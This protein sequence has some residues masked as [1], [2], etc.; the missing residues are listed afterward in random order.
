[1]TIVT[2]HLFCSGLY[3]SPYYCPLDC[4]HF[5]QSFWNAGMC[6]IEMEHW[7]PSH[8][9]I[10]FGYISKDLARIALYPFYFSIS[11]FYFHLCYL[12]LCLS[13]SNLSK[14]HFVCHNFNLRTQDQML[15]G[16]SEVKRKR[17]A[18]QGRIAN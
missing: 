1:M 14:K 15:A 3:S 8:R 16:N 4:T 10:H 6:R 13:L 18:L 11:L 9:L 7:L 5:L 12:T 17:S 2:L